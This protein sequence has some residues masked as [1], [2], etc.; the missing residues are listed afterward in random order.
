LLLELFVRASRPGQLERHFVSERVLLLAGVFLAGGRIETMLGNGQVLVR[1][2]RVLVVWYGSSEVDLSALASKP[3]IQEGVA[4][5]SVWVLF[6][7]NLAE[8]RAEVAMNVLRFLM[9]R[10]RHPEATGS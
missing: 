8:I 7:L 1:R 3:L 5:Q 4:A 9:H 10:S 2:G 6:G